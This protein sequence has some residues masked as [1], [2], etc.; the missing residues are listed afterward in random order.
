MDVWAATMASIATTV[1]ASSGFWA[2]IQKRD[3][4]R[5]STKQLILGLTYDRITFLGM[6]YIERGYITKDEYEDFQVFF[7][8]PYI[9]LG[10]NGM[11]KKIMKELG[12]LPIRSTKRAFLDALEAR[13]EF[14]KQS[15]WEEE[16]DE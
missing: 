12:D 5:N 4:I 8:D 10:G 16:T 15:K 11:A 2:W 7:Y 9:E 14:D 6:K 1:A 13:E 3:T